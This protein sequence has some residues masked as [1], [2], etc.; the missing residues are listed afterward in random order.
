MLYSDLN[1]RHCETRRLARENQLLSYQRQV[2]RAFPTCSKIAPATAAFVLCDYSAG[3]WCGV[4][5]LPG[6]WAV[7]GIWRVW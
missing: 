5:Q 1:V 2:V 6:S 7:S 4:H 3:R